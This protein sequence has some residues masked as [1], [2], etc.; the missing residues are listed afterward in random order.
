MIGKRK[1][2][3]S[4]TSASGSDH[5]FSNF[6]M[7]KNRRHCESGAQERQVEWESV[8]GYEHP[9]SMGRQSLA[10]FRLSCETK[11]DIGPPPACRERK[12]Q[13]ECP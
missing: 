5:A 7:L 10:S 4:L 3:T 9:S 12:K 1:M 8:E 6:S 11:A 2:L 13:R